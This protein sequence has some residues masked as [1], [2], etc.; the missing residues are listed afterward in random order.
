ML[1]TES[2]IRRLIQS[3]LVKTLLKERE[4]D[5]NLTPEFPT[6][7]L[8]KATSKQV[9]QPPQQ[10]TQTIKTTDVITP[11]DSQTPVKDT[12]KEFEPWT[13]IFKSISTRTDVF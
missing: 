2:Q 9:D 11:N 1:I 10:S 13:Y 12:P 4:G 5:P 3:K 6:T 7:R 8:L